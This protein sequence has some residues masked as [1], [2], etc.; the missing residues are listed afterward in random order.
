M[1]H[2]TFTRVAAILSVAAFLIP[3]L[4][5]PLRAASGDTISLGKIVIEQEHPTGQLY[6]WTLINA[7]HQ[8]FKGH[9][10]SKE[11]NIP[12]GSYTFFIDQPDGY[13]TE[14]RIY[15][16]LEL[17]KTADSPQISFTYDGTKALRIFVHF[18]LT[19]AGQV[20]V[21]STPTGI[22]YELRGPNGIVLNDVTPKSYDSMP[23]GQYSVRYSPEGCGATPPKS[24]EL[25]Y[26]GRVDFSITLQCAA[27]QHIVEQKKESSQYV[28][29]TVNGQ[30]VVLH[31]VPV[32]SWFAVYVSSVARRGIMSGYKNVDGTP[33]DKF[34]P[35]NPVTLAEVAKIMHRLA[36]IEEVHSAA[37]ALNTSAVGWASNFIASAEGRDWVVY[38][39]TSV[40]VNRPATRAEV[41]Q[42]MLQALDIPLKWP[43]G[44]LFSDVSRRTLYAAAVET[45]AGDGIVSGKTGTG[46]TVF[47][48]SASI[49]RAELAKIVTKAMEKYKLQTAN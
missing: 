14:V 16:G 9:D 4:P 42:T 22:P 47:E 8:D 19:Y 36:G 30:E 27:L 20:N 11:V 49:N 33:S 41:L 3:S 35:E 26:E 28:T 40:E 32:T 34:G 31:D 15:D 5:L 23:I 45:A 46:G 7:E 24:D 44:K 38:V 1:H 29:T 18:A 13:T 21:V 39:D 10:R 2:T 43:T 25:I 12:A 37:G 6:G 48:P 17:V